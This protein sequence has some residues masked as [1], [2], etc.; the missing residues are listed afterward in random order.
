[1]NDD[2][3]SF[4]D[5]ADNSE[6]QPQPT[7]GAHPHTRERPPWH[8][9]MFGLVILT[10]VGFVAY[11]VFVKNPK[12]RLT[13]R[14]MQMKKELYDSIKVYQKLDTA[15]L[16][17]PLA[18]SLAA[19]CPRRLN[20]GDQNSCVGWATAY[21]ARSILEAQATHA[22]P[23]S[24]AF[25]PSYI[26]NQVH[27]AD[28]EGSYMPVALA[29]LANNG[30]LSLDEFPYSDETCDRLPSEAQ[31]LRATRYRITGFSRLTKNIKDAE[32]NFA[33]DTVSV[34][35]MLAAGSPVIIGAIITT[36][37]DS[38]RQAVWQPTPNDV[39]L[40]GHA[41]CVVGYNDTLAGGGAFMLMNSWGEEWAD[42]GM[43]WVRYR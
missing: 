34:K 15:K 28:C 36:S 32:G 38:L 40:G 6:L 43:A 17:L 22:D 21:A 16:H 5:A 13:R 30:L 24:L 29:K 19:Y 31:K 7:D 14:G 9:W 12:H 20:Q 26:Y 1:M 41:M 4:D 3:I 37:F 8:W 2:P 42:K 10:A 25:S 35:Q 11:L 23:N 27:L 39:P 33:I 18:V